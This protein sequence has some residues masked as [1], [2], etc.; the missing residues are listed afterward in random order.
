MTRRLGARLERLE[1]HLGP[2]VDQ[3]AEAALYGLLRWSA[4]GWRCYTRDTPHGAHLAVVG[5]QGAL[6][7]EVPGVSVGDLS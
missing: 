3:A 5:P 1:Q 6:V 7:Y 2:S 4:P